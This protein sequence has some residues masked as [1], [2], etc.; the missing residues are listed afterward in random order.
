[1][2]NGNARKLALGVLN[3]GRRRFD[4]MLG[5]VSRIRDDSYE[6]FAVSSETGIP[7]AGDR[8][9]LS[10]VY[11]RDVVEAKRTVAITEID[12]V[13]GL[14]LHPLYDA[15]PC[16]F[17]ISS[18]ILVGGRVWGTVNFT[19]LARRATAFSAEDIAHNEAAASSIAGA[20]AAEGLD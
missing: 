11:C 9:P 3:E 12:G 2:N 14:C 15:V 8:Y 1:M 18:P 13:P 16:E 17:Y 20:I 10:A 7:E 19:S 4:A 6:I 5:I